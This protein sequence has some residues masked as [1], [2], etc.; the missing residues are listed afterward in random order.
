VVDPLP[1][2]LIVGR[3]RIETLIGQGGMCAVYRARQLVHDRPVAIKILPAAKAAHPELARRFQREV[4]TAQRLAH[5]N[6]VAISD[7]GALPDGALFLV[8]ELLVGRSLAQLLEEGP[9]PPGRALA[10]TR[11]ILAGL[12]EAHRVGI[13]HRDVKPGNV[14]LVDVDGVETVKL[15]DFGIA[16]NERAAEKLTVAGTA[17]GTPQ[18]ISPEMARGQRVDARA[19]LYSLGVIL[20]EMVTGRLPFES[21]DEMALLRAHI[22]QRP[23]SPRALRPELPPRLDALILRALHKDPDARFPSAEAMAAALDELTG[24]P[25]RARASVALAVALALAVGAAWWWLMQ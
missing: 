5:P 9:L 19:D 15:F 1:G 4:T 13:F 20:F 12:G 3:Y 18:Y 14:M 6:V 7:S 11:Q 24:P 10:I 16:A 25:R 2:S 8:M 22:S 17:F 21:D 23:P